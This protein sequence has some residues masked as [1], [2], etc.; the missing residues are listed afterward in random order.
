[1]LGLFAAFIGVLLGISPVTAQDQTAQVWAAFAYTVYGESTPQ[2]FPRLKALTSYGANQLYDAGSAFRDRYVALHSGPSGASTRIENLSPYLLDNE[3]INVASTS[4]VAVVASAQAFMQGLYPPLD[5]SFNATFFEQALADGSATSA[6]LG[7]YQYPSIITLGLE[8]PRS[9]T[10]AAQARCRRHAF[11]N[12]EYIGSKEFWQTYEE[13]AVFYNHLHALALSEDF[14]TTAANYANATSISEYLD[15]QAVHNE[16]LLH[17]LSLEDIKRARWLAGKYVFATNGNASSVG[18]VD[19]SIRT[20]AGQGLASS[21]LNAFETNIQNRGVGGKMTLQFGGPETAV[22]FASLLQLASLQ[23]SNFF[24]LPNLGASVVLELFSMGS[25]SYPTYPDPAQ[26]YIR[27]LLRNGTDA[28][29]VPYP[30]F[31]YSP[32]KAAVPFH[33]FQTQM[34]QITLGPTADWCRRCNAS[35]VFCSAVVNAGHASS[36]QKDR[37]KLSPAVAGVIGAVVTL[38][39][40][41]LLAVIC[42][43]AYNPCTKYQRRPGLGGFK[44]DSKMASDS[45]LTFKNAEWGDSIKTPAASARAHERHGSWEMANHKSPQRLA[46]QDAE[47]SFADK[48]DEEWQL[49]SVAEP[50]RARE[51][52]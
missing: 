45:D 4:D 2:V 7:G 14:D 42:V 30:L 23:T 31:G 44:G 41:A 8:D 1:M 16:S 9:L 40:L 27:F 34:Q 13:S 46:R 6:P 22:S 48:I 21:V 32:S 18:V 11:A 43:L 47:S 29:F 52:V 19:G 12:V 28:N 37:N 51:H 10:I 33:E 24:S 3:D 26:L 36:S 35:V 49:H 38:V 25:E 39:V 17:S 20:I 50:T 15:Y 5:E